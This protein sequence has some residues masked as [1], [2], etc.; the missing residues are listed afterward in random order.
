MKTPEQ[1]LQEVKQIAWDYTHDT[2][3][4]HSRMDEAVEDLL[5]A[6]GYGEA[7]EYIRSL[8]RWYA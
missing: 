7:V 4:M 8:D 6:L 1:F 5:A 3:T 2:E